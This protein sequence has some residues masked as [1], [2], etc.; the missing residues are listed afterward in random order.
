MIERVMVVGGGTGGHLFP[1]IAVV[2]EL[3]RRLPA[4]RVVFVGTRRGIESRVLPQRRE[5]LEFLEVQPLLGRTPVQLAKSLS[6]LPRSGLQALALL[7]RERPDLVVGLGGY[8]AGPVLLA[9]AA[10]RIPT[11]LLEQNA[12]VGLTN[13]LLRHTVGRA[14]LTHQQTAQLFG[15]A[16]ARVL[17]NPVRRA[18]VE[19]AHLG[20]HDPDG[21]Q[22]S[23]HRILVLGGSQGAQA[24]NETVPDALAQAGLKERG[25][26]VLHPAGEAMVARVRERYAQ[27]GIEAEVV[28]FVDDMVRAYKSACLVIGRAG[29][30]T[31]AELCA[32]G[33]PSILI[34]FPHAAEDHQS[35]N[36][37]A[38]EQ[39]GAAVTIPQR[40]LSAQ[41]LA[42]L[43]TSLL[44]DDA[45]RRSM[46]EAARTL[47]KPDAAA[48]IVD[49]L[50]QWLGVA[51]EQGPPPGS[52]SGGEER[53]LGR[54]PGSS[55]E[56]RAAIAHSGWHGEL[57][58]ASGTAVRLSS[59]P[60]TGVTRRP[61]V[62]R[63]ELRIQPV[64][65]SLEA[66]S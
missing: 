22:A 39:A 24:L 38:L 14:Y 49:D 33:R 32:I 21:M 55:V 62:K 41:G 66:A 7:G 64:D 47:G 53:D 16:R 31:L 51:T 28:P 63:C 20:S 3:R 46:A 9:A 2:E 4:V 27:L 44:G 15:A 10:R 8:V 65:V 17:G 34:P 18:F 29:A 61:K 36:A 52:P 35:V 58:V 50:C 6:N 19:A 12:H 30:T 40:D 57:P 54:D 42:Q 45:R 48:A 43:V 1:G 25:I 23:C 13:R 59:W 37:A 26:S 56:T 60:R 5:R 11:A